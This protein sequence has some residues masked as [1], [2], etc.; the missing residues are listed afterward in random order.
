MKKIVALVVPPA[1]L[2][3]GL[4]TGVGSAGAA[5]VARLDLFSED[6]FL[7][8]IH[9]VTA[10]EDCVPLSRMFETKSAKNTSTYDA[11]LYENATCSGASKAEVPVNGAIPNLTTAI[12]V[13]S[14]YFTYPD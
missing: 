6:D 12:K 11:E 2:A 13:Q 3:I 9:H 5:P 4:A 8:K 10:K 14:V 1:L 7:G